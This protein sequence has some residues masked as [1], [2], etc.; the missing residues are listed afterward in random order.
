MKFDLHSYANSHAENLLFPQSYSHRE[1]NRWGVT[2][3][4]ALF[5]VQLEYHNFNRE[6]LD[7]KKIKE[8]KL[9]EHHNIHLLSLLLKYACCTLYL[10]NTVDNNVFV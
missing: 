2:Q 1:G 10:D 7:V 5:F 8:I 4:H 3:V 6:I 9:T